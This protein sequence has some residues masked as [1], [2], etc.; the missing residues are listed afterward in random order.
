MYA[1]RIQLTALNTHA[2]QS[3]TIANVT[4]NEC[5]TENGGGDNAAIGSSSDCT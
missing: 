2:V 4:V 5:D 3:A 1:C